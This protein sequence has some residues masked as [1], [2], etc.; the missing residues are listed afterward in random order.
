L[1][2][3]L[4]FIL[5]F[6]VMTIVFAYTHD[7]HQLE[8]AGLSKDRVHFTGDLSGD[9]HMRRYES[10]RFF[11][12]RAYILRRVTR[13]CCEKW[14]VSSVAKSQ[15]GSVGCIEWVCQGRLAW[16]AYCSSF[17][18][19]GCDGLQ[20]LQEEQVSGWFASDMT[21]YTGALRVISF[22]IPTTSMVSR[23]RPQCCGRPAQS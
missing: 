16:I 6:L 19:K 15:T 5:V 7:L 18:G 20:F 21:V 9:A 10:P 8:A 17:G 12:K 11:Q 1:I 14:L 23:R 22:S 2:H 3:A 13:P 4:R